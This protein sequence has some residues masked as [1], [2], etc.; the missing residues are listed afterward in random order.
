MRNFVS[1]GAFATANGIV[2]DGAAIK[3]AYQ[4]LQTPLKGTRQQ[5]ELY[6]RLLELGVVNS[7]VCLLYTSPSPRD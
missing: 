2:P 4:A 3:Q 5:N 6:E 1:A 7:N